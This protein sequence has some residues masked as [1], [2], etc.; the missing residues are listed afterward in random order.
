MMQAWHQARPC[1]LEVL[2]RRPVVIRQNAFERQ[3]KVVP[4]C[5]P[6]LLL[7][8]LCRKVC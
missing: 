5:Y 2:I 6:E 1:V 7:F 3:G 8:L 4:G